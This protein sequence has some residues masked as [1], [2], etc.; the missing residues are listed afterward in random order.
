MATAV[1]IDK[2]DELPMAQQVGATYLQSS[3]ATLDWLE[4]RTG[5]APLLWNTFENTF[6][7]LPGFLALGA[8]LKTAFLGSAV[9]SVVGRFAVLLYMR[10]N[11]EKLIRERDMAKAQAILP[12]E[13]AAVRWVKGDG[14]VVELLGTMVG[15]SVFQFP[16]FW[17][18]G[19]GPGKMIAGSLVNSAVIEGSVLSRV[20]ERLEQQG[21]QVSRGH[22]FLPPKRKLRPRRRPRQRLRAANLPASA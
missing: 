12:S 8:N 18:T 2:I 15:R 14:N 3:S 22:F 6:F 21:E 4:G 19:Y 5:I 9:N 17:A 13:E 16:G 10:A 20:A 11:Q 7:S 1:L